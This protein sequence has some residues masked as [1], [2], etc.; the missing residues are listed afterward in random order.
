MKQTNKNINK[1]KK[2]GNIYNHERTL[3]R[4][5]E[6]KLVAEASKEQA[7]IKGKY[8]QVPGEKIGTLVFVK[9][10][11]KPKDVFERYR[12]NRQRASK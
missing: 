1:P 6:L 10:G 8:M 5:K 4:A 11:M 3:S 2:D 9:Q 7:K 12:L